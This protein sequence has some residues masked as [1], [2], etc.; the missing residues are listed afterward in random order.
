MPQLHER[1]QVQ[2]EQIVVPLMAGR[3]DNICVVDPPGYANVGDSAI[4]LGELDL[5]DRS[6]PDAEVFYYDFRNYSAK[7]NNFIDQADILLLHGGGNF[8]DIW[9]AHHEFRLEM[10]RRF[11]NKPI[12]Q[13]PQSISISDEGV[14]RETAEAIGAHRNFTLLVRD[15]RS[16]AFAKKHFRCETILCPD[17]AF[18]ME[19]I[20]RRQPSVDYLCLMRS[21]KEAVADHGRILDTVRA[22]GASMDVGDWVQEGNDLYSWLDYGLM[23]ATRFNASLTAPFRRQSMSVRRKYAERRVEFGIDLLSRGKE[24]VTDRLHA[25]IMSCLL[26]IPHIFFDSFDGKVAGFH[27]AWTSTAGIARL[28]SGPDDLARLLAAAPASPAPADRALQAS[29]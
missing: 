1:L 10:L 3:A 12:V 29:H 22:S 5:I 21:D 8:G 15:R 19:P 17:M 6:F 18:A 4:L 11:P 13:M 20:Q 26:D 14:L 23:R 25:H 27:E 28:A 16:L 9:P 7:A 2:I 24:V